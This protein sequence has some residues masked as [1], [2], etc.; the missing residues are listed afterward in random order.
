MPRLL[1]LVLFLAPIFVTAWV[2]ERAAR[3]LWP[4][5]V[6][7]GMVERIDRSF[8]AASAGGYDVL[9]VG[10]SRI[11]RGLNPDELGV[12]A[13]NFAQDEASCVVFGMPKEAI[14]VG[15]V[16]EIAPLHE[17]PAIVLEHLAQEHHARALRV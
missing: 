17:L 16:H 12:R 8:A 7:P 9:L 6:G 15:G 13:Y 11:Y 14:A 4:E 3:P 10:N 5:A 2:V 1:R